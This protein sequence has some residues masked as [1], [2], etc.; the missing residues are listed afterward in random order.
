MY[1]TKYHSNIQRVKILIRK[2]IGR[3]RRRKSVC[4]LEIHVSVSFGLKVL[5]RCRH[6]LEVR[7]GHSETEFRGVCDK[8]IKSEE[9]I[10]LRR[11]DETRRG[12]KVEQHEVVDRQRQELG[13]Q[14]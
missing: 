13:I 5:F 3:R 1:G 2:R 4:K 6:S 14:C 8:K 11:K 10:R 12:T 9:G 7:L